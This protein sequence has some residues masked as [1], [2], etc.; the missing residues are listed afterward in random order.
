MGPM[1]STYITGLLWKE[2]QHSAGHTV[3]AGK[4]LAVV[5]VGLNF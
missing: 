5:I 4:V 1:N 3:N 2:L